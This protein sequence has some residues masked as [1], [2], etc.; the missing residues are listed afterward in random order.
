MDKIKVLLV[1]DEDRAINSLQTLLN[2]YFP[3]VEILGTAR[4][5]P[6]AVLKINELRPELLFLDIEMPEYNGFELLK[7]FRDID[8]S[9]IFVTAYSEYALK[10]F[11][12]SA[13]D[14][15]LKPLELDALRKAVEK[16]TGKKEI[17]H[18][19]ERYETLKSNLEH[20]QVDRIALPLSDGLEFIKVAEIVALEADGAYTYVN[21]ED[22]RRMLVSKKLK[23]F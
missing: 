5:V 8:F 4:N 20:A 11:E 9:I 7:F 12:V 17:L 6:E 3:E 23:F 16:Y 2:E 13:V 22:N 14:Y 19:R 18:E 15:I 10:A 21:T 1:D